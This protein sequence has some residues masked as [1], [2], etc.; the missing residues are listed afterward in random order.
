MWRGIRNTAGTITIGPQVEVDAGRLGGTTT[1]APMSTGK[2]GR[3]C[4]S[5]DAATFVFMMEVGP[6]A[7]FPITVR[8]SVVHRT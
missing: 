8:E 2:T 7:T 4:V 3:V 5:V 6:D 1:C